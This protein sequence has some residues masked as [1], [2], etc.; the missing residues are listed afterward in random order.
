MKSSN[1][2]YQIRLPEIYLTFYND[3]DVK[4]NYR[5]EHRENN[6]SNNRFQ[7]PGKGNE[8]LLREYK[9]KPCGFV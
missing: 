2:M 7:L 4:K 6:R 1:L 8:C 3:C 5:K 9:I